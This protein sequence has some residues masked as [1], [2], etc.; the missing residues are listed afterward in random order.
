MRGTAESAAT[1]ETPPA[2]EDEPPTTTPPARWSGRGARLVV[3][4]AAMLVVTGLG[5]GA[6][7]AAP[8]PAPAL[9]PGVV[10]ITLDIEHSRFSEEELRVH[11]GTTVRFVVVNH[12]PI[13]HELVVGPPAVHREHADGTEHTHPPVPGEVSVGPNG[14]GTTF[15]RFDEP[16]TVTFACHLPGHVAYGMV[17]VVEVVG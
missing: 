5:Y 14:T 8:E 4:V 16:G 2:S 3:A 11:A 17:G 6:L 9:G 7:A 12:D 15:Y 1:P 13:H 10:T